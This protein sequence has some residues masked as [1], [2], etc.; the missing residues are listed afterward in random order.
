MR[1]TCA[2]SIPDQEVVGYK[3]TTTLVQVLRGWPVLHAVRG[4]KMCPGAQHELSRFLHD[5]LA[6]MVRVCAME[7]GCTCVRRSLHGYGC[8]R[9]ST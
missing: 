4:L 8:L 3:V 7:G 5:T 6:V 9:R 1:R 2:E